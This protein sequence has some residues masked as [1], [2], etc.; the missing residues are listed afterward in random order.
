[1]DIMDVQLV[2]MENTCFFTYK[3]SGVV[4]YP[5]EV[6]AGSTAV[7]AKSADMTVVEKTN[8]D[9]L[10]AEFFAL[11]FTLEVFEPMAIKTWEYLDKPV[12][13]YMTFKDYVA[14]LAGPYGIAL[15]QYFNEIQPSVIDTGDGKY[16]YLSELYPEHEQILNLYNCVIEYHV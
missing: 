3:A 9:D 15:L 8:M 10:L 12:R 13:L 1:M 7:F 2:K 11:G 14:L 5:Q 6:A 4:A 16:I